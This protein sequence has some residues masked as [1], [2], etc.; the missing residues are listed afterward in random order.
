ML[1]SGIT[2]EEGLLGG[3]DV[4]L[5]CRVLSQQCSQPWSMCGQSLTTFYYN[6]FLVLPFQ[7]LACAV[8]KSSRTSASTDGGGCLME[9]PGVPA[10]PVVDAPDAEVPVVVV[11]VVEVDVGPEPDP[12]S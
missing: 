8:L 6:L 12:D 3:R 2:V 5:K 9:D 11:D 1:A 7:Y 10:A 4:R